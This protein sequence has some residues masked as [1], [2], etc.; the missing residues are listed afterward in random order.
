[1]CFMQVFDTLGKPLLDSVFKGYNTCLF[2]YGQTSAGKSYS[3]MGEDDN[4][5]LIPRVSQALFDQVVRQGG[6]EGGEASF[7]AVVR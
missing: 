1:M 4:P 6:G 5:G 7:K 3:M 2:A